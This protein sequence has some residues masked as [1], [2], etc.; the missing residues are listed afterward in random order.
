[1]SWTNRIEATPKVK[2]V[3]AEND[4]PIAKVTGVVVGSAHAVATSPE[5]E[6]SLLELMRRLVERHHGEGP[7]PTVEVVRKDVEK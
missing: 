4:F 7:T 5:V 2:V 6:A 3:E 1:M